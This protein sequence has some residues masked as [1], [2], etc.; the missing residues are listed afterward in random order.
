[1]DHGLKKWTPNASLLKEDLC[2]IPV[3]VKIHYIPIVAFTKDKLSVMDNKLGNPIMLDSYT[4]TKCMQS[5][6][7]SNYACT[8]TNIRVNR[9]LK[10][11]MVIVIPNL[12]GEGGV[13]HTARVEYA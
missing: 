5:W 13:L 6:G 2:L 1:M 9:E 10:E 12:E 7:H 4:S 3:W 11:N 8:L